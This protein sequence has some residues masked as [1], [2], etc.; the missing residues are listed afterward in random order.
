M[1]IKKFC[2]RCEIQIDFNQETYYLSIFQREAMTNRDN[3][4]LCQGCCN[5]FIKFMENK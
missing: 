5:D 4:F 3:A 2:S 1:K